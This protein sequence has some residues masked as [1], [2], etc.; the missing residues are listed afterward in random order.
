MI[1]LIL[2]EKTETILRKLEIKKE[3]AKCEIY[4]LV[5]TGGLA[6]GLAEEPAH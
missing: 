2:Y 3:D 1:I 4:T 5:Y 6:R